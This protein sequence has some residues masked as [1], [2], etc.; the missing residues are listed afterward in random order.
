MGWNYGQ[1]ATIDSIERIQFAGTQPGEYRGYYNTAPIEVIGSNQ[2]DRFQGGAF[3][4]T[5]KGG[6]GDDRMYGGKGGTNI[7]TGGAGKDWFALL[8]DSDGT[9]TV[10]DFKKGEDHLFLDSWVDSI[11]EINGSTVITMDNMNTPGSA[12]MKLVGVTGIKYGF[13][14]EVNDDHS[15]FTHPWTYWG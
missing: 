10:T 3:N 4:D 12:T 5:F 9:V 1:I 7:L 14:Y 8:S 11:Q 15:A 6:N 2:A 13:D